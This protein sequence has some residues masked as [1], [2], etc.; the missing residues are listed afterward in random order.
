MD[1]LILIGFWIQI[2]LTNHVD[3]TV[4]DNNAAF[5]DEFVKL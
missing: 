5:Y 4:S 3:T 2:T 1:N